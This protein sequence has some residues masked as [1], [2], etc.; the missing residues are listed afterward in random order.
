MQPHG[1]V[2]GLTRI[3][4]RVYGNDAAPGTDCPNIHSF[5]LCFYEDVFRYFLHKLPVSG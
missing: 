3:G 1:P 4:R 2:A 5:V